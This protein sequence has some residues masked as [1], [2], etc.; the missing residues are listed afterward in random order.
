MLTEREIFEFPPAAAVP[1]CQL[2]QFRGRIRAWAQNEN[3]GHGGCTFLE[4]HV[5]AHVRR[6]DKFLAHDLSDVIDDA[7]INAIYAETA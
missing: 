2:H 7:A 6:C 5:E 4:D 1:I 3:Y